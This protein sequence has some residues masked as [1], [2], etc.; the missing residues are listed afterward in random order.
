MVWIRRGLLA[1]LVLFLGVFTALLIRGGSDRNAVREDDAEVLGAADPDEVRTGQG[2]E[3]EVTEDGERRF[4]IAADRWVSTREERITLEG[5]RLRVFRDNGEFLIRADEGIYQQESSTAQ[6]SGNVVMTTSGGIEI[7]GR[8]F[9][10]RRGGSVVT[11]TQP[12]V[13][14]SYQDRF[15]GR[16]REL[17]AHLRRK[18]YQLAGNVLITS[19]AGA[20]TRGALEAKRVVYEE[21]EQLLVAEGE[22]LLRRNDDELRARRLSVTLDETGREARFVTARW[23]VAGYRPAPEGGVGSGLRFA[24]ERASV[25][26]EPGSGEMAS[27]EIEAAENGEATLDFLGLGGEVRRLITPSLA[28]EFSDGVLE[29]SRAQGPVLIRD[30]LAFDEGNPMAS[31]CAE[32]AVASFDAGGALERLTLDGGVD[33][34]RPGFQASGNRAVATGRGG[35]LEIFGQ[36]AKVFTRS[37]D[38]H[39]PRMSYR[40]DRGSG[41]A[42]EGVRAFLP[43][44]GDLGL[45]AAGGEGDEPIHLTASGANW[46]DSGEFSFEGDVRAW[47]KENFLVADKLE[48]TRGGRTLTASGRVKTVIK[49]ADAARDDTTAENRSAAPIEVTAAKLVYERSESTLRYSGRPRAHQ[50]GSSLTC[51]DLDVMLAEGSELDQMICTGNSL[52][53]NPTQG[54]T[55]TGERAVYRPQSAS[56]EISG[57]PVVLTDA[58]G[59][60]IRG[61]VVLYDLETGTARVQTG[62]PAPVAAER[63]AGSSED[64]DS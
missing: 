59:G 12:P 7:R 2:F 40:P 15:S 42:T 47:Q 57:R 28:L 55:V 54:H 27:A 41:R 20:G 24:G 4:V 62:V 36:P 48:G 50:A 44:K 23:D 33:L 45:F 61:G 34:H 49:D 13:R 64:A 26:F 17:T 30:F 32:S 53:E 38:F 63:A 10:L 60:K 35:K 46:S 31:G 18:W 5:I 1:A 16:S 11:S 21:K 39:A 3:H 14:F 43:G 19:G 29:S 51:D 22:V 6:L 52:I 37:G 8:G 9:E 58:A 25:L 56:V